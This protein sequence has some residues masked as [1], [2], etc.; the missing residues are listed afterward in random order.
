MSVNMQDKVHTCKI[1]YLS[2][3]VNVLCATTTPIT[4]N[5]NETSKRMKT[6]E[7]ESDE[8]SNATLLTA[9]QS[10]IDRFDKQDQRLYHI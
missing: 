5:K 4:P 10:L 9:I 1:T 2:G 7:M 8:I 3:H 6:G